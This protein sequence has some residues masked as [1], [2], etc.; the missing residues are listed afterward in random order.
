MQNSK[1]Q[2]S[3]IENIFI[4]ISGFS[5]LFPVCLLLSFARSWQMFACLRFAI[6]FLG[7]GVGLVLHVYVQEIIG[8]QWWAFSSKLIVCIGTVI[9]ILHLRKFASLF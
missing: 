4:V 5:I 8:R 3:I 7:G 9:C 1:I 2:C 6:G